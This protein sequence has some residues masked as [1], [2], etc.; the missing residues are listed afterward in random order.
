MEF[1]EIC[2]VI[3]KMFQLKQICVIT[4]VKYNCATL[5][6]YRNFQYSHVD[7]EELVFSNQLFWTSNQPLLQLKG[8]FSSII[9]SFYQ[10]IGHDFCNTSN[11]HLFKIWSKNTDSKTLKVF[12]GWRINS[13][14]KSGTICFWKQQVHNVPIYQSPIK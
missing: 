7:L 13:K 3:L 12:C 10:E 5:I 11:F 9:F 14:T 4:K 6:C 8:K 2:C 1:R